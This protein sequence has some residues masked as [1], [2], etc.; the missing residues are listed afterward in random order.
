MRTIEQIF[1]NGEFVTP[2]GTEWFDLYNPATAQVI[3]QVRL[4]DEVDA[5]RAAW[6]SRLSPVACW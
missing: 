6:R 5:A 2:H 3:G 1:I 4:A